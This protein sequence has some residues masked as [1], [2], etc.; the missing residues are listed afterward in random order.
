MDSFLSFYIGITYL[1]YCIR[2]NTLK[3]KELGAVSPYLFFLL[4][5]YCNHPTSKKQKL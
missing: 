1:S 3:E 4:L 5:S 2:D